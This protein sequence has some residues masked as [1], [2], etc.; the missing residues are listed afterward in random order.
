MRR[1]TIVSCCALLLAACASTAAVAVPEALKPGADE[2]LAMIVSARGVQ[3]Y[4]CRARKDVGTGYEWAFVAPEAKLFDANGSAIGRHGAGPYWQA[5]DGSRIVGTLKAR[6][7]APNLGATAG[8][9]P[10]LLLSAK[11]NGSSGAFSAVTSVQRINTVGGVA[12]V[13]PCSSGSTGQMAR[14][15]YSADYYFFRNR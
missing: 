2:T 3:I 8:A 15:E 12:P 10:W 5:T 1:E 9:I 13:T 4:E 11:S 7:D 14:V 6:V